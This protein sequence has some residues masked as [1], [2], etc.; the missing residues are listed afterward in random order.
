MDKIILSLKNGSTPSFH[1][2]MEIL[3]DAQNNILEAQSHRANKAY[4]KTLFSL[5]CMCFFNFYILSHTCRNRRCLYVFVLAQHWAYL[6]MLVFVVI[7]LREL[8]AIFVGLC[9]HFDDKQAG[10]KLPMASKQ[11]Q[12]VSG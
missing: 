2:K 10:L 1:N 3:S 4:P 8:L 5:Q 7:I 11:K 6:F 12:V 9:F